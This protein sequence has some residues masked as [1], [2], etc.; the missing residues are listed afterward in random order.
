MVDFSRF[1]LQ[2][3]HNLPT[4]S[5]IYKKKSVSIAN[6][7]KKYPKKFKI[8]FNNKDTKNF[9]THFKNIF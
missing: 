9:I 4:L 8:F 5:Q 7:L 2:I 3:I 6:L 1:Y